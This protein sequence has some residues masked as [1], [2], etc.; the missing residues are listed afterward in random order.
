V[1]CVLEDR[2]SCLAMAEGAIP[3]N[4]Q[5]KWGREVE[6]LLLPTGNAAW[7]ALLEGKSYQ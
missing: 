6:L 5:F 3:S 1:E 4:E 2:L 7:K